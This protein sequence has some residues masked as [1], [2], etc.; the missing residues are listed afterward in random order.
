M[1]LETTYKNHDIYYDERDDSWNIR[2]RNESFATLRLARKAVD[3]SSKKSYK[4]QEVFFF[5]GTAHILGHIKQ[6]RQ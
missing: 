5:D 6:E 4:H 2:G 1:G 3:K